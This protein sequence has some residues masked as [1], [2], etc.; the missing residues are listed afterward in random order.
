MGHL[1]CQYGTREAHNSPTISFNLLLNNRSHSLS[2][3]QPQ[4]DKNTSQTHK[5]KAPSAPDA[6]RLTSPSGP[7]P[8][9]P[10]RARAAGGCKN[11]LASRGP[12]P[13]RVPGFRGHFLLLAKITDAS[14]ISAVV[15]TSDT[16]LKTETA[17]CMTTFLLVTLWRSAL[18]C[19][20]LD[21]N[22]LSYVC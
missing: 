9:G 4:T 12:E 14:Q 13:A 2:H 8:S 6:E 11:P 19:T 15:F 21:E 7:V 10:V 20:I 22:Q 17:W 1:T 18:D 16:S 3:R 5:T